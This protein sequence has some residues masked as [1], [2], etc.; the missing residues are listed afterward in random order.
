MEEGGMKRLLAALFG[1]LAVLAVAEAAAG[2][3]SAADQQAF[4]A[5][6]AGQMRAFQTDDGAAA[7][8]YASPAIRQ[9]YPTPDAF[10]NMVRRGFQPVYRPQ[11]TTFGMPFESPTGPKQRVL[12]TGPDGRDWTAEY[13][14]QRQPDGTWKINGCKL[15]EDD[16]A[17]I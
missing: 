4:R 8:A 17:T 3:P 15:L 5:I 12:V 13:T 9:L 7:Y 6:I 11:S 10:M 1:L 14:L 16:G 2:E